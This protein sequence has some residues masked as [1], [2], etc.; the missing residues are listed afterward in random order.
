MSAEVAKWRNG[1]TPTVQAHIDRA[2]Q[3]VREAIAATEEAY[4]E[5]E[6]DSDAERRCC[7]GLRDLKDALALLRW[8]PPGRALRINPW[9]DEQRRP[10]LGGAFVSGGRR[11]EQRG[12][13]VVRIRGEPFGS[14]THE[15]FDTA[16]RRHCSPSPAAHP[17]V[18]RSLPWTRS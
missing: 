2:A 1:I 6:V 16:S 10:P 11:I 17:A 5:A 3:A 9:P 4:Q 8:A 15:V 18:R 13:A 14:I 12:V 7:Q